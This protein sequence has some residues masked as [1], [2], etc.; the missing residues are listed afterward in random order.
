MCDLKSEIPVRRRGRFEGMMNVVRFNWPL[1]VVGMLG[2]VGAVVAARWMPFVWM[3]WLLWTGAVGVG[4]LITMSLVVSHWIYDRSRLYGFEWA[5]LWAGE[6]ARCVVNLHSG[7]DE[8]SVGLKRALPDAWLVVL[9]FYDGER[10]TEASIARARKYQARTAPSWLME[11][12]QAT[13]VGKL[14]LI[15]GEV[16]ALFVILAAHEIREPADRVSF[17]GELKR[18]LRPGGRMLLLE[19]LRDAA[20]FV[21]FG[22]QFVH[23][24]PRGVWLELARGAG[25]SIVH[26]ERIT[27]FIGLFVLEKG[28]G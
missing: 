13:R 15:D 9:D 28:V 10:M 16:D 23:F 12:T 2:V 24:Y 26:E 18:I 3:K 8:T 7:F 5:K 1:Y 14:P 11:T 27:P 21:A 4:Y 6:G 19:H 25:L 17:F 22:P 20:N